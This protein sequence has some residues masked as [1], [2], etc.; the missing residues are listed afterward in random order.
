ML[1]ELEPEKRVLILVDFGQGLE[2]EDYLPASEAVR[3]VERQARDYAAQKAAEYR[4]KAQTSLEDHDPEA[5]EREIF[6]A[7][8]L[9]SLDEEESAR[10]RLLQE[11]KI[12][13]AVER[14]ARAKA[15]LEAQKTG[16]LREAWQRLAEAEKQDSFTP[17]LDQ[18]RSELI[19]RTSVYADMLLTNVG[20]LLKQ[21]RQL[22]AYDVALQ[23]LV[24]K[25][26]AAL[27][28]LLPPAP[29]C[30]RSAAGRPA[31]ATEGFPM[32]VLYLTKL[33]GWVGPG[34]QVTGLRATS[35]HERDI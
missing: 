14:R 32:I 18:L 20:D 19:Q 26:E 29:P 28:V 16:E 31:P 33:A 9:F 12:K 35:L 7:F 27:T 5:A 10:C 15:L 13:P 30:A 11:A 17:G 25:A 23:S 1:R 2:Y 6:K 21:V 34:N 8:E 24:A 4:D 3:V 22:A